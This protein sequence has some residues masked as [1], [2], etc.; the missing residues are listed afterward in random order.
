[1]LKAWVTGSRGFVGSALVKLLVNSDFD[2]TRVTNSSIN[3]SD[4]LCVNYSN[5]ECIRDAIKLN[6]IPDV[7]FHL[8]WG[9]VYEPQSS[10]HLGQNLQDTKNLLDVL[11]ENG[12][13]K[14]ILVGS[15]SE[16]GSRDGYLAE[17]D[18]PVGRLT[19]YA[20]GKIAAC[21]YGFESAGRYGKVFIHVRLF[22]TLGASDRQ[23]ALFSQLYRSYRNSTPLNLSRCD[24]FRD[25]TYVDDAADG[26]VKISGISSSEI[27]NLGSGKNVVLKEVIKMFWERLEAPPELLKFGAHERPD[28]EPVQP[29]CFADLNKL[30]RL[31]RWQPTITIQEAVASTISEFKQRS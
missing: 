16:Y 11:Y 20:Q 1:M 26:F 5:K 15:S 17:V 21:H 3:C 28:H 9:N 13:K 4:L 22:H 19:N 25:Y 31:T 29:H 30:K 10:I 12:L 6:G 24:Q 2:V 8:G 14:A 18:P 23:D 27:V 7:L